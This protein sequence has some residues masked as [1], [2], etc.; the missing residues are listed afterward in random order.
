MNQVC[1][2][3]AQKMKFFTKDLVIFTEEILNGKLHF[4]CR[5]GFEKMAVADTQTAYPLILESR[6]NVVSGAL[7]NIE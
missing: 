4:L 7:I 1:R 5:D 3:T 2:Y 6:L